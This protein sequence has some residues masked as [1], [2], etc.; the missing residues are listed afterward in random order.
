MPRRVRLP[1]ANELFR[2]T[3]PAGTSEP[4][5]GSASGRVKHD[6]KITVYVSGEEL[7]ALERAR[8]QLRARG[9]V[10]DRGRLVLAAIAA[11]LA[12]LEMHGEQADVLGRL[13][14]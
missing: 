5:P 7:L 12:D 8:L 4:K 1:G 6:E 14:S 3:N 13:G 9:I 10:V 11:A 2:P